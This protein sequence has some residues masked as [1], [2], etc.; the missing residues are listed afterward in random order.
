MKM[1]Y[2]SCD[3]S[4]YII[5]VIPSNVKPNVGKRDGIVWLDSLNNKFLVKIA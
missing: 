4:Y 2:H 5:N 3:G 1:I